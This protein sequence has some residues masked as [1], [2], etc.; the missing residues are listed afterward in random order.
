VP[1]D[2]QAAFPPE[3][4][5][6]IAAEPEPGYDGGALITASTLTLISSATGL[7]IGLLRSKLVAVLVGSKGVSILSN[8]NIYNAF[9][10]TAGTA[11]AGP[12]STR[13]IAAARAEGRDERVDWLIRYSFL[14]PP[15]IGLLILTV[16]VV[17]AQQI[18][19]LV[20]GDTQYADLVAISA[21]AIPLTL[22]G[23]S[24]AGVLQGFI[25]IGSLAK[26]SIATTLVSLVVTVAFVLAFGLRG[27]IVATS[28]VA[29]VQVGIFLLREPW[30]VRE[31]RWRR[32][33]SFDWAA[34]HPVLQL[35]LASVALT[36][37][38]TLVALLI[39]SDIV[40]VVGLE[41]NGVYQPVAAISDTY[42][43]LLISSTSFY[44]FPRLT[45][46]L[47]AGRRTDASAEVG[48]GL[49]VILAVTVVLLLLAIAFGEPIVVLLYS[50]Q[51]RGAADPLAI[52]MTGN[53]LKV[54]IWSASAA[55]LPLG[56][57]RAWLL[58]GLCHLAIKYF[59]T[60]LLL[61]GMGLDGVA[62]AYDLAWAFTFLAEGFLV[63]AVI[64]VGPRWHDW[65]RAIIAGALVVFTFGA[66]S[67]NH[68]LGMLAAVAA[69]LVWL[70][71]SRADLVDLA[72]TLS[73][74]ARPR[75]QALRR[76]GGPGE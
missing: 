35:G 65:Q 21:V 41:Q 1:A 23:A 6:G 46:L 72:R 37:A 70:A 44:L 10:A 11:F 61:P 48:H 31:R 30:V 15:A 62:V 12:G 36:V 22:L 27:A 17:F 68:G 26:A 67:L 52:Q 40:R 75:L 24:Y 34:L 29:L 45:E 3:I 16:T 57:Y 33:L 59:G 69:L 2:G 39:R 47:S 32:R 42:L 8:L 25:R 74:L 73:G 49:R 18:S 53:I 76:G 54:V 38:S 51:F 55:L 14:V 43:E 50:D 19:G 58:L 9:A 5:P 28:I 71:V 60:H 13:A 64:K 66:H 63:V 7:V 56:Y 4:D 20:M